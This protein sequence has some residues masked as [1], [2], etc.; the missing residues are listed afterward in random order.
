MAVR[1]AQ[2]MGLSSDGTSYGLPP[3]ETEM[4]RRLWWQI[5]ILDCRTSEVSGSGPSILHRGWTTNLP[6]N[7]NDSDLYPGMREWPIEYPGPTE[8]VY[9]LPRCEAIQRF[10]LTGCQPAGDAAS[11]DKEIDGLADHLQQRHLKFCDASVPLH[12]SPLQWQ[13]QTLKNS[14]CAHASPMYKLLIEFR[15]QKKRRNYLPTV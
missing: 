4:R 9:A 7:N 1:I 2:R 6:V 10:L 3:F 8:M 13:A 11:Q 5:I 15:P 14:E 12:S